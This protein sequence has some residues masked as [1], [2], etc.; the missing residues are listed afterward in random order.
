MMRVLLWFSCFAA[1]AGSIMGDP[2]FGE[3]SNFITQWLKEPWGPTEEGHILIK[4]GLL[5]FLVQKE[6]KI[7]NF[8]LDSYQAKG[9]PALDG[10]EVTVEL[11]QPVTQCVDFNAQMTKISDSIYKFGP[12]PWNRVVPEG[13]E[14][15]LKLHITWERYRISVVA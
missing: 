5:I 9:D 1:F 6:T 12:K 7:C 15:Q 11:D 3:C 13:T 10:W 8:S 2:D 4:A 14:L